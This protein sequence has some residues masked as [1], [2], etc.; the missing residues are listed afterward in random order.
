MRNRKFWNNTLLAAG[1]AVSLSLAGCASNNNPMQSPSGFLPDYALLKPVA[2]SPAGTKIY[3]YR[4]PNIVPGTYQSVIV[5]PVSIYQGAA[6]TGLNNDQIESARITLNNGIQSIV[7]KKMSLSTQPGPGVARM[8]VAITGAE[9]DKEG[10]KPRNLVPVSAAIKL[11]SSATGLDSKT[12]VLVVEIKFTDS[13]SGQLL[14]ESL[15]IINGES[16]RMSSDTSTEFQQLAQAWVQQAIE[17]SSTQQNT[18][19][20]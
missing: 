11:A 13:V 2:N 8:S 15:T 18:A 17:Y 19:A 9:L 10:F 6:K 1:L 14:R 20:Q 12:P 4:N 5:D 16:F 3:T 7:A